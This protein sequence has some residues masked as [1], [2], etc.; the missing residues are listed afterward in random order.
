MIEG[1]TLS[2]KIIMIPSALVSVLLA[3]PS[4]LTIVSFILVIDS[5]I[6]DL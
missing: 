6:H 2:V 1:C 5:M 3:Q 4:L